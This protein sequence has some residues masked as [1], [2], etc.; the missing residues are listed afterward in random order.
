MNLKFFNINK[1]LFFGDT[2][3]FDRWNWISKRLPKTF[4][5]LKLLDV[6][7]G[8]GALTLK[9]ASKGYYCR[10]L[11]W[12]K[13]DMEKCNNRAK[14]C[15]LKNCMF[16]VFDARDLS[17]YEFGEFDVI[18]NT[19]NIEHIIDDL[20]LFKA[21]YAKLKKGGYLLLTTPNFFYKAITNSDN[22]NFKLIEDGRHVRRGYTKVMLQELCQRSGFKVQEISSCSG[23]LSQKITYILRKFS[24]ILGLRITWLITLPLRV[25]PMYFDPLIK[26]TT[27]FEDYSICLVAYKPR[28]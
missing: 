13:K 17:E 24:N 1:F 10:G 22:G 4:D 18:I 27:N 15:D 7:C 26:A 19:E 25:L 6:G 16:D 8:S 28:F 5:N 3:V 14:L 2:L 21:I 12:S 23:Y 20:K 9:A 11:S